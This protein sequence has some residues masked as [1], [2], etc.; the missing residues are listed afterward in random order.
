MTDISAIKYRLLVDKAQIIIYV[1]D[2]SQE[3]H[4]NTIFEIARNAGW[5]KDQKVNHI[6]FGL[7]VSEGTSKK[8]RSSAGQ[9]V[10]LKEL[11]DNC[12][13]KTK[14][15]LSIR[16]K[17]NND[18]MDDDKMN[19]Q[20]KITAKAVSIGSLKYYDLSPQHHK[21]YPFSYNKMLNLNGSSA[22]YVQYTYA[23]IISIINKSGKNIDT[24]SIDKF[25]KY[26][27]KHSESENMILFDISTFDDVLNSMLQNYYIYPLCSYLNFFSQKVNSYYRANIIIGATFEEEKL[28]MCKLICMVLRLGCDI[29]GVKLLDKI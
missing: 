20:L 18:S 1:T 2:V 4:F 8:Y 13:Q 7:I 19:D 16:F 21:S 27:T 9:S 29:I 22:L 14:D 17:E 25:E 12:E 6:G 24:L 28:M 5:L 3:T 10:G 23:R 15:A 26:C 11:L